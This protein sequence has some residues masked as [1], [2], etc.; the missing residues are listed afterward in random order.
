MN[1]S[2]WSL[3]TRIRASFALIVGIF[4]V[5]VVFSIFTQHRLGGLQDQGAKRSEDAL[6]INEVEKRV[7]HL[8]AILGDAEINRELA[9][10]RKEF[11]EHKTQ[12]LVDM[13]KIGEIAD[14]EQEKRWAADFIQHYGE[15]LALVE[16]EMLPLLQKSGD[17]LTAEIRALDAKID[18]AREDTQKPLDTFSKSIH[19]A[20]IK[21]D[22][23]FDATFKKGLY[24]CIV[25]ALLG[26]IFTIALA[27][28]IPEKIANTLTEA[29]N[30]L[31]S[32]SEKVSSAS[33]SLSSAS[34]E[35]A[36][37][38][39][40][41]AAA[42]QETSASTE[43]IT[44]MIAKSANNA[45][46]S[47]SVASESSDAANRGKQA[48]ERMINSIREIND[49]NLRIMNQIEE[50]NR[51]I[52]EITKVIQE[53]GNKTKVI[54]DIV[55][56][57]KLLSFNASVEAARAGEQGKGFAV[58]AEEVGNLAQMSGNAATEI[59]AMLDSSIQKV[60][61]VVNETKSRVDTLVTEGK[62]KVQAGLEMADET[63]K[64]LD[65]I[66]DKVNHVGGIVTD[67]STAMKEQSQGAAEISKA[68]G[69]LD[70]VTQQNASVSQHV[71][72]SAEQ[73]NVE[74][75]RLIEITANLRA[76]TFGTNN[77]EAEFTVLTHEPAGPYKG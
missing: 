15:Y 73:L 29:V 30:A 7:G 43:E 42:V 56:Q 19:E 32:A 9:Q 2:S 31:L 24:T 5:A 13:K 48:S 6:Q 75:Q 20:S 16:G 11:E 22:Q 55:F 39:S 65:E 51:K 61:H 50:S 66:L 1:F 77:A 33:H 38:N 17:A 45:D 36:Q 37:S 71:A 49:S 40:E 3:K 62:T 4:S 69:Q 35:L 63:G 8:S 10:S 21:G 70:Q 44:A 53:I 58:V 28:V 34:Q 72:T 46:Q 67:I 57:T 54:N 14:T 64:T 74:A 68:M 41:Q 27:Y 18:K 26:A 52:S 76:M 59:A 12:A 60:D 23:M 47:M 25:I